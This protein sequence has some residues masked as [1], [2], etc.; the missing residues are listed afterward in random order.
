MPPQR[1]QQRHELVEWYHSIP[2]I[3]RAILTLS[4]ATTATTTFGLY[5]F[6]SL[7][8]YWPA[9]SHKFQVKWH[10]FIHCSQMLMFFFFFLCIVVALNHL[11]FLQQ[12]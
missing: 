4:I 3:T 10:G 12:A 2:P 6:N 7:I 9:I 8:Y 1:P 11:F 5:R